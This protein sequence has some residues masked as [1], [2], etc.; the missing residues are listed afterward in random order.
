M[1]K[2]SIYN[3]KN[4]LK[5]YGIKT[6]IKR[7]ISF[8]IRNIFLLLP[9][10]LKLF[11]A[12]KLSRFKSDDI[13][14]II[15]YTFSVLGGLIRP[16]QVH[17][18]FKGFLALFKE[19][20]PKVIIEIGTAYGGSLFALCKLAPEDAFTISIDLPGGAFGD[21]YPEWKTPIYKY[22]KKEKQELILLREDSHLEASL[23]KIKKILNGKEVDFLFIDG[24]HTYEG[25]KQDFE[26]YSPLVK[27]DGIIAFHDIAPNGLKEFA[28]GVPIFWK[29]IKD[30]YEHK[31]FVKDQM[32]VGYGIGCLFV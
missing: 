8:S 7:T 12:K 14:T 5:N 29:E 32:Q 25:V 4:V 6:F 15:N 9:Q 31:E 18:E 17:E 24:D 26:M 1:E 23:E 2:I 22:F 11:F 19:K 3:A 21:G 27:K 13:D 20:A 16:M 30:K 10:N 28:G